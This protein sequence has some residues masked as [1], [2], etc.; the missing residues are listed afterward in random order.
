MSFEQDRQFFDDLLRKCNLV[1]ADMTHHDYSQIELCSR[2]AKTV[3]LNINRS[4][5]TN[6]LLAIAIMKLMGFSLTDDSLHSPLR[7]V[8]DPTRTHSASKSSH[9]DTQQS[10]QYHGATP[11]QQSTA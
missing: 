6:G 3:D 10:P 5:Y 7:P 1:R 8:D 11:H 9:G 4:S 2:V